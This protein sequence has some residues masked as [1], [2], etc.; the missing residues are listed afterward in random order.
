MINKINFYILSQIFKSTLLILFIFLTISWLLQLTRLLTLSN[1]IQIDIINVIFLSIFLIPNLLSIILPFIIIFGILLC[2]IK[3]NRDKEI[4]AIY[5]LGFKLKPVQL[6]IFAFT[7]IITILYSI[8]NFYFSPKIYEKYKI[9]EFE[10]R[11][12]LNFDKVVVSN[13]LELD[14]NTT[15]DFKKNDNLYQDIFINFTDDQENIIFSKS[16]IIKNT[17]SK[18]IFQLNDGF[19]ISLNE[20]SIEKLEF[21]NYVLK[22]DND[23]QSEFNNFDKNTLTIFDDIKD[24]NYLN[25]SFKISDILLIVFI[26]Y[27]FYHY[28]IKNINLSL[29]SNLYFISVSIFLLIY[30]QLLKNFDI[31]L[32]YYFLLLLLASFLMVIL[33]QFKSN[34]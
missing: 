28:N 30:N 12:T 33:M 27:L 13:F 21:D 26:I 3:L 15:L 8:L 24:R 31:R 25:I 20:D 34:E 23:N 17:N 14:E 11:N 16:G 19:K 2:F 5:S 7:I 9:L 18:Y 32:L 6:S 29:K 4:V 22:I 1:L 10:L